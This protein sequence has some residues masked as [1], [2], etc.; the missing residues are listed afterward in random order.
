M[1]IKIIELLRKIITVHRIV[2]ILFTCIF[3]AALLYGFPDSASPWFDEGLNMG[4]AKAWVEHGVYSLQIGPEE[5]VKERLLLITTNYPLLVFVALSFKI[6]GTHLGSAKIIMFLFL[7]VFLCVTYGFIRKCYG[8]IPALLSI[9]LLVTFLPFYGNGKSVLGEVPG[10][11][12]FLGGLWILDDER[13]R[14]WRLFFAGILFGL[15]AATKPIY[16]LFVVSI[17]L[18]E[19][20]RAIQNRIIE[21]RRWFLIGGGMSAPL[22][23]WLYTVIPRGATYAYFSEAVN[24]YINPYRING[25]IGVNIF[26][27]ISESTPIH[28]VLLFA[29]FALAIL[30]L[31][32]RFF[33][34]SAQI[35]FIFIILN[36][37]FYVRTVGWYRYFFPAHILLIILQLI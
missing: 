34:G 27:F 29:I 10:L 1:R 18:Y 33:I 19:I 17:G 14:G 7:A 21:W 12:Y 26:R 3:I 5:F 31:R 13:G 8:K 16:F 22:S 4:I 37:I 24:H 11:T 23:L 20:I 25:V 6:F 9:G 32:K 15:A 2:M 28:F 36:L 35:V 30:V